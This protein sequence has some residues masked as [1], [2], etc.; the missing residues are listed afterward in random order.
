MDNECTYCTYTQVLFNFR[1]LSK[2]SV[3]TEKIAKQRM[4]FATTCITPHA[5]APPAL[6]IRHRYWWKDDIWN[7]DNDDD[8]KD[9]VQILWGP[10]FE[11]GYS[12]P[13]RRPG[14]RWWRW[15]R[16]TGRSCRWWSRPPR[17]WRELG[18][19]QTVPPQNLVGKNTNAARGWGGNSGLWLKEEKLLKPKGMWAL[20]RALRTT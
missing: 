14:L 10:A 6:D 13:P 19:S 4:E 18:T 20:R 8:S 5:L 15:R 2:H 16:P 12:R 17:T 9:L 7:T 3:W 1:K 11:R